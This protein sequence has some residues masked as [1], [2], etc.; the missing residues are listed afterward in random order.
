[1][2]KLLMTILKFVVFFIG[3][4]VLAALVPVPDV[5]DAALWR[6]CAEA[7]PLGVLIVFTLA[8]WLI[9]RRRVKLRLIGEAPRA[10]LVGVLGGVIWTGIVVN[11]LFALDAISIDTADGASPLV[12]WAAALLL[13]TVMQELLIRGYLYRML[14]ASYNK[15][16]A[17][18]VTT[19]LFTFLHGGAIEAGPLAVANVVAMSLLM[20]AVLE[21]TGS[22]ITPIC[23]HFIWNFVCGL[24]LGGISLADDYPSIFV[25]AAT[26]NPLLSGG[27][28]LIEA[29]VVT[30]ATSLVMALVFAILTFVR[31]RKG[32]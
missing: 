10:T 20:C 31:V 27:S 6:L 28:Y 3:W 18:L 23:M 1:M 29:S 17:V 19:A 21:W 8:F 24:V 9:E 13:N 30:L 7:E 26:G 14:D 25:M 16:A 5:G 22:L 12:V 15:A 4:A 11:V 32:N 2:K